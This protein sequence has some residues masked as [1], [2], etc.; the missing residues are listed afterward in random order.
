MSRQG[1]DSSG[2]GDSGTGWRIALPHKPGTLGGR[3]AS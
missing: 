1:G 3:L 2:R